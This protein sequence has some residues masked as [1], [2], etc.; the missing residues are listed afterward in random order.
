MDRSITS[1]LQFLHDNDGKATKKAIQVVVLG[2]GKDTSWFRH[3]QPHVQWY[4]VDHASVIETKANIIEESPDVFLGTTVRKTNHG[5]LLETT[6]KNTTSGATT[7]RCHLIKHDLRDSIQSLIDEKLRQTPDFDTNSPTLFLLECVLMYIPVDSSIE[8][9]QTIPKNFPNAY[10]CCYEPILGSD[11]FGSVMERNL[12]NAG[13]AVMD[14][15]L[16]KNRSLDAQLETVVAKGG[17][18]KAVGCD[19]YSAYE[20]VM[21]PEQRR[22]ANQ[23]EILDEVEEWMLIMRHYC[24]FVASSDERSEF[25]K[26]FCGVGPASALGFLP[27]KSTER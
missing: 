26:Y 9:L 22:L 21:T 2:S 23:C 25:S 19:M 10:L 27:N 14:C 4:E 11:T 24:L 15:C 18:T 8:I 17:F 7:S 12:V 16:K 1:F 20:T 13:V 5:Y 3:A 6:K